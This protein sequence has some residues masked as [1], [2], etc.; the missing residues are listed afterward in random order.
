[1]CEKDIAHIIYKLIS[2]VNYLHTIDIVHRDLKPDNILILDREDKFNIKIIDFGLS[3]KFD[4][5][6]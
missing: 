5:K 2:A 6:N 1:M 3:F 4:G